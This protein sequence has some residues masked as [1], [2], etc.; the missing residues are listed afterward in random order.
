MKIR[1][2][3][4]SMKDSGCR[5]QPFPTK[6]NVIVIN[7]SP[8]PQKNDEH[9]SPILGILSQVWSLASRF[10]VDTIIDKI[11]KFHP[12]AT[13][14]KVWFFSGHCDWD[15]TQGWTCRYVSRPST[16]MKVHLRSGTII[17]WIT[18]TADSAIRNREGSARRFDLLQFDPRSFDYTKTWNPRMHRSGCSWFSCNPRKKKCSYTMNNSSIDSHCSSTSRFILP[19]SYCWLKEPRNIHYM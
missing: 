8:I 13:L 5:F 19:K 17:Q 6:Q 2:V 7:Y 3:N 14:E 16:K 10:T 18:T 9:D 1:G 15:R 4:Y 12:R 11:T